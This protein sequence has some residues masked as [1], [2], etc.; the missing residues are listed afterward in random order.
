MNKSYILKN[1]VVVRKTPVHKKLSQNNRNKAAFLYIIRGEYVFYTS[2]GALSAGEN[3]IVYIPKGA[4]YSY[5]IYSETADGI[6]TDFELETEN[7]TLISKVPVKLKATGE[8][9]QTVNDLLLC[10]YREEQF[11]V[12]AKL[13]CLIAAFDATVRKKESFGKISPAVDF[14]KTHFNKDV[15]VKALADLCGLSES[16]FRRLFQKKM[17]MSPLKYK[18]AVVI[19]HA[20][21]L[22]KSEDMNI[23][24]VAESLGFSSI[25]AFSRVFKK[26][27]GIS[28]KK[29]AEIK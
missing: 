29:Y 4:R 19:K 27:M 17:K 23:T 24:E 5:V 7:E 3:D 22:L 10:F 16:H 8:L 20:C 15:S 12:M 9:K 28:P 18:T 6:L 13:F 2:K 14:L 25:Y 21:T 26:E 1:V 11:D